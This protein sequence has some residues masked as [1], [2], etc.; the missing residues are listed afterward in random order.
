MSFARKEKILE[1]I[2]AER[3][4]T[5]QQLAERLRGEG[6][7]VTQATVSRD[8]NELGL[9]KNSEKGGKSYYAVPKKENRLSDRF[10]KI[11]RESVVEIRKAENLIV[12]HTLSGCASPACEAIDSMKLD[13]IVGTLAG[14]NTVLIITPSKDHALSVEERIKEIIL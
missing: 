14:E 3:I 2:A 13:D 10:T 1:I 12:I 6:F 11:L 7:E 5:Q 9:V 4:Q 8:I